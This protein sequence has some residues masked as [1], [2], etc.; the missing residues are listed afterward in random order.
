VLHLERKEIHKGKQ[1]AFNCS[2]VKLAH[3]TKIKNEKEGNDGLGVF[4]Q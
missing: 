2:K 3:E 1:I 4:V